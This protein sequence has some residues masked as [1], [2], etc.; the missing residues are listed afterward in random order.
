MEFLLVLLLTEGDFVEPSLTGFV[1]EMDDIL[2]SDERLIAAFAGLIFFILTDLS[3]LPRLLGTGEIVS[4]DWPFRSVS[5]S[6]S[7]SMLFESL[8]GRRLFEF[9]IVVIFF[10]FPREELRLAP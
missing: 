6:P 5:D 7:I 4:E 9:A 2:P 10:L 1:I 3:F 8:C